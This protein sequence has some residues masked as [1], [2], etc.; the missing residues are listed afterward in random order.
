MR[1]RADRLLGRRL[2]TRRAPT[3]GG[4]ATFSH[5]PARHGDDTDRDGQRHVPGERGDIAFLDDAGR[6]V[7][8]RH[9]AP[10]SSRVAVWCER[11]EPGVP[12]SAA[13]EVNRG[14]FEAR[15]V[16]TGDRVVGPL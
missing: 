6:I 12:Y 2:R 14:F 5:H 11:Y 1:R 10:C 3:P 16:G 15:E 7:A 4:L 13:L 8:I 9:M